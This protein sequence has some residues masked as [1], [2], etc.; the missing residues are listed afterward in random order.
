MYLK[1]TSAITFWSGLA[2]TAVFCVT[3]FI[4][5]IPLL[6]LTGATDIILD[7]LLILPRFAGLGIIIS[8][9]FALFCLVAY[10]VSAPQLAKFFIDEPETDAYIVKW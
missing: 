7:P 6:K 10:E 5:R 8:L 9:S 4:L 3:F 1:K 2:I